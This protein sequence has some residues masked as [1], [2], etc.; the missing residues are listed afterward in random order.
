[1]SSGFG[2]DIFLVTFLIF[3]PSGCVFRYSGSL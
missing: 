2:E 3:K 1:M